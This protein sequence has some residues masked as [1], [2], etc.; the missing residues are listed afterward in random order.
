M[1]FLGVCLIGVISLNKLPIQLLPD[2]EFPKL[3]IITPYENESPTEVETLITKYVEE[4]VSSVN[5]VKSV[6]SESIE[7][8]SIVTAS[9]QWGTN[10]DTAIIETKEKVDLIK[11]Q[12][13]QDTGKSI[14]S[15]FDPKAEPIVIYSINNKT[16]DFRNIRNKIEKEILPYIERIEGV[17]TVD[18]VGGYRKQINIKLDIGKIYS[19]NLSLNEVIDSINAANY[20]IPAGSL[21]NNNREY[22]IRTI[23]EFKDINEVYNVVVGRN[24]AGIPIYL[25]DIGEI[26]DGFKDRKCIIKFDGKEAIAILIQ[27][28]P[29]KNTIEVCKSVKQKI[30]E[31]QG[32]YS[33]EFEIVKIYDQSI[34]IKNSIYDV[35]KS[36]VI[37]GIIAIFVLYF[38]LKELK[39][40]L[41]IATSI[42]IS[43]L[44]TF[45]LMYFK[46]I[47]LNVMSLGGLALGVGMMVDDG[48]VVLESISQKKLLGT[49]KGKFIN[50][51]FNG[52]EEVINPVIAS[53]LTKIVVFLPIT[54]LSSLSGAV[55]GELAL[56]ISFALICSLVSSL[57]LMPML[58]T[59]S[60]DKIKI[61]KI[62]RVSRFNSI[63]FKVSDRL[64]GKVLFYYESIIGYALNNKRKI[65]MS[66]VIVT[67]VGI[68]LF[69]FLD[70]ELM[71]KVDPGEFSIEYS[72]P[73]GTPLDESAIFSSRIESILLNKNYIESIYTKISSDPE[74]NVSEKVSGKSSN[75]VTIQVILKKNGRPN[76]NK[77]V[78]ELKNE[79]RVNDS[80]KTDFYIKENVVS[81]IFS[82]NS[83]PLTLEIY[84]K[85]RDE[86]KKYGDLT[87]Q[88]LANIK[89]VENITSSLDSGYP[90]L[91]IN[92]N[93]NIMASMAV[94]IFDVASTI[95][96]AIN[97]EVATKYRQKDDDIDIRVKINELN[98]NDKDALK[99]L[100]IKSKSGANIPLTKFA[101]ITEGQ[102][103][104]KVI[105]S[106]QSRVNIISADLKGNHDRIF[107][108]VEK[109]L[110]TIDFKEGYEVKIVGEKAEIKK[111]FKELIFAFMLG[112]VL[113]YMVLA[114]EFQSF[115][116]PL[117]IMFSIPVALLGV[118]GFLLL[119]GKT[120]NIN[121]GIGII[122]L[123][124]TV[125]NN[126]IVLFDYIDLEY[127][128]G[129]SLHE[130]I[131]EAGKRRI[132]PILI[133]TCTTIFGMIPLALGIGEGAELQQSMAIAVIGGLIVSTF[134]TLIFIPT[135]FAMVNKEK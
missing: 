68:F 2:I 11:G 115:K 17:A 9:F 44:G 123:A 109:Q 113:I 43:I 99:N 66:G 74:E 64:M 59:I 126:S 135:I 48:V 122:L 117:I 110:Q 41:I 54:F 133:T 102:S 45:A 15:K 71:P 56:T 103:S 27:K 65:L 78:Q 77:I 60:F 69:S 19:H 32:K 80:I 89:G 95:R 128:K 73:K 22:L 16:G 86:I 62:D 105:R 49:D 130:A 92:I 58:H 1:F 112:L 20:N 25:K 125:V 63:F 13:P 100:L 114:S 127:N 40:P 21:K 39:S 76:V 87:K 97:G 79:I 29:S 108:K 132:K 31:L 124:G 4:A 10:M 18:L 116:N 67:I 7:G 101:D 85:E 57:T 83:K 33:K 131:V 84:G 26:D 134:L 8:L 70:S 91:S 37:G 90:E 55:F 72:L 75:N 34:F 61:D 28:E 52:T 94:D 111:T 24:E 104:S 38:F 93:R 42:P 118:S 36:A 121:S 5:G 30:G 23:G 35:L 53:T 96:T 106:D 81:S 51:V 12:L 6:Y 107:K 82:N 88:L 119:T 14:V 98:L 3:T 50:Y 129:C 47:S 46:G 120:L